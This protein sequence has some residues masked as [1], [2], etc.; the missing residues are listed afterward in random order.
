[1][2]QDRNIANNAGIFPGKIAGTGCGE[3]FYV[4]KNTD[5][6]DKV[7]YRWLRSRTK[8]SHLFTDIQDAL[9]KT[10]ACRN[11][12]VIVYP[13]ATDYDLTETLT[14]TKKCVHLICPAGLGSNGFPT[15]A[16]RIDMTADDEAITVTGD[17]VE[18]AGFFFK[19][20]LDASIIHLSGTRW[21]PIIHDNFFGMKASS[22]GSGNYGIKADGACSHFS[23][24]DNYFTNYSPA[25]MTGT[26]NAVAGFIGVTNA[27]S[28][29]GLIRNN[30]L[31]TGANTTV[32]TGIA[33][34]GYG[35]FILD[36]YLWEDVAFGATQAGVFTLG[37][38]NSVD[39][40]C[41]NNMI[42]I[43][44]AANGVAGGTANQS[45]THNYEGTSGGTAL[46]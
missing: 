13:S 15:N 10:V 12:Y 14:M 33:N 9:D 26:D 32:A 18:I 41:A 35:M 2:I 24:Y 4:C 36:N 40:F 17:C 27:S 22:S 28:T 42:G 29:R 21:H 19:G 44:T 46:Q 25:A 45:Y 16:A 34:A 39:S 43:A 20:Y 31:H 38:S 8:K 37:I 1:M 3:V 30:L 6:G 11:D 5:S 23:F 7:V